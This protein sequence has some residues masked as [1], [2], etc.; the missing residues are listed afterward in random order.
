LSLLLHT[1]TW[2][3]IPSLAMIFG[4]LIAL[5][6]PPSSSVR[7][8]ILH[9]AAGVVFSVVAVELLPDI[10]KRHA[11]IE[12]TIGFTSGVIVML[13]LRVVSRRIAD[14]DEENAGA[15]LPIGLLFG[16][17]V[18]LFLDGL[19][20]GIGFAAG[21]SEGMM[22][23]F[24]LSLELL[25]LGLATTATLRNKG[26]TKTKTFSVILTLSSLLAVASL[27]GTTV[28]RKLD[29]NTLEIVLSFGLAALLYLVTEE[30]LVEA[31]EDKETPFHTASFFLGFLVLLIL[32]MV[33]P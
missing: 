5:I 17:A 10:V 4:A 12:I 7:G 18:D 11:P 33:A 6:K 8:V 2:A 29:N 20:L 3:I 23:A 13:F 24:A 9:F 1:F 14:K 30:L 26:I 16:I 15:K 28:L 19:L 27:I 31:H 21:N 25:T 22:L 32:G